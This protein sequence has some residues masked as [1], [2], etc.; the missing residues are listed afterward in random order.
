[1]TAIVISARPV[2]RRFVIWWINFLASRKGGKHDSSL[3]GLSAVFRDQAA[4]VQ[5]VDHAWAVPVV[6]SESLDAIGPAPGK[7]NSRRLTTIFTRC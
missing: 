3:C 6:F 2:I 7:R 5:L 1:M 4:L